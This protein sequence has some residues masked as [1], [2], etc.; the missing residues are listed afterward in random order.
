MGFATP[1]KPKPFM[2]ISPKQQAAGLV[3]CP[4]YRCGA[5]FNPNATWCYASYKWGDTSNTPRWGS[6]IPKGECPFCRT[7]LQPNN[8]KEKRN[9]G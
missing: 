2:I 1:E 4:D 6:T 7:S 9:D 3:Q 5:I 8:P